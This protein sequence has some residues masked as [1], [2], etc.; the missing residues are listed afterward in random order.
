M[1]SLFF[2]SFL[3]GFFQFYVDTLPQLMADDAW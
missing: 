3:V 1:L 2:F